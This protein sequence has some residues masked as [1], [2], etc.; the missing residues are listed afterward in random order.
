MEEEVLIIC[1]KCGSEFLVTI[2]DISLVIP[3]PYCGEPNCLNC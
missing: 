1:C 2:K 3:C